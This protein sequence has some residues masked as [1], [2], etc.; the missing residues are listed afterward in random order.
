MAPADSALSFAFIEYESRRDADDAYH[1]MHNKRIGRDDVLK[2]EVRI[3]T[4]FQG[5]DKMLTVASGLALRP[6]LLGDSTPAVTV[7][8][9]AEPS[10]AV[11]VAV[12]V[13]AS[14][15]PSVVATVRVT[16]AVTDA[17]VV[18]VPLL[19][20]ATVLLLPVVATTL[21]ARMIVVATAI[22]VTE[23][24]IGTTKTVVARAALSIANASGRIVIAVTKI[25]KLPPTAKSAKVRMIPSRK[26]LSSTP[27]TPSW[28]GTDADSRF[29]PGLSTPCSR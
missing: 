28:P 5:P 16:G 8:V 9:T 22:V 27:T 19:V 3:H 2:I 7:A 13:V 25:A 14:A 20:A 15:A 26:L 10:V 24:V 17:S 18:I 21:P 4:R 23:I 1:E 11:S 12:S 29:S 6:L